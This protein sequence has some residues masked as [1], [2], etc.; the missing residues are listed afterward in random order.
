MTPPT[1]HPGSFISSV[2]LGQISHRS[3]DIW[4]NGTCDT[5]TCR[6]YDGD[7]W[8]YISR[9]PLHE[10]VCRYLLDAGFY[11]ILYGLSVNGL[12]VTEIDLTLDPADWQT[13][14]VDLLGWAPID[15]NREY[16]G[17]RLLMTSLIKHITN[18]PLI[19][20]ASSEIDVQQRVRLYLLWIIGGMLAIDTSG[21][22][23]K[24]MYLHL[25]TDLSKVGQYAWGAATL[26]ILYRYLCRASQKRIRVIGDFLSLLQVWIYERILPLRQR[27]DPDLLVDEWLISIL[28]GPPR[29]HVWSNGLC[30]DT[31][32]P[33]LLY[34]FRDQ[35]DLLMEHQA[36]TLHQ[37]YRTTLS[38][39]DSDNNEFSEF[40]D[41]LSKLALNSF[42]VIG[43]RG[44]GRIEAQYPRGDEYVEPR[45][46]PR[47]RGRRQEERPNYDRGEDVGT[48]MSPVHDHVSSDRP[49]NS[50]GQHFRGIAENI[51]ASSLHYPG[52]TSYNLND[53]QLV[54]Y[55][56]QCFTHHYLPRTPYQPTEFMNSDLYGH[57]PI[58]PDSN[59]RRMPPI[60]PVPFMLDLE[61]QVD[62]NGVELE[63]H[64]DDNGE[65]TLGIGSRRCGR[66]RGRPP[67]RSRFQNA[68]A[69]RRT[70][71]DEIDG[72]EPAHP[73]MLRPR[74][75]IHPK[76]CGTH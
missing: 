61:S 37:I 39:Q 63:S 33:Y 38:V 34:L 11:A 28:P 35:L 51:Y 10:R 4:N 50:F 1:V 22:K 12:P 73:H 68:P 5:L 42:R 65:N 29:A 23:V 32:A 60:D 59:P 57:L 54:L 21:N 52:E 2:L 16:Q 18:L 53:S 46:Q 41:R 55:H 48:Q 36:R 3:E 49:S 6:R 47:R 31:E 70:R 27:R 75:N 64:I 8:N 62:D 15:I 72:G 58:I 30:H 26:A 43:E 71:P 7:F 74:A 45:P 20:N 25:L 24:L 17:G 9:N 13:R 19:T 14:M 67:G 44:R 40:G 76:G 56:L 69:I 66:S